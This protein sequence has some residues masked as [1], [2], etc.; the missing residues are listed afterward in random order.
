MWA[1]FADT[2]D[3]H[4]YIK[5]IARLRDGRLVV[6]M[7]WICVLSDDKKSETDCV[8]VHLVEHDEA[9]S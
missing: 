7:K 8:D 4:F 3:R 1:N 9:V 5:E 6:P 2:P